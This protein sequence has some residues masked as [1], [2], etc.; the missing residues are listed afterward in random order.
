MKA[1][2][3]SGPYSDP[4][5]AGVL[6]PVL[7]EFRLKESTLYLLYRSRKHLPLKAQKLIDLVLESSASSGQRLQSGSP[8]SALPYPPRDDSEAITGK[9]AAAALKSLDPFRMSSSE[10]TRLRPAAAA[11][12]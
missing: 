2:G 3:P 9:L 1:S 4:A 6:R 5:F 11:A 10:R 8:V 12:H 7:S